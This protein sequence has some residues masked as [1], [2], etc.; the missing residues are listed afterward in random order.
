M[1]VYYKQK[2]NIDLGRIDP[3]QPLLVINQLKG[4]LYLPTCL[5]HVASLPKDFTRDTRAMRDIQAY[6]ISAP[7][8]RYKRISKLMLKLKENDEFKRWQISVPD[9]FTGIKGNILAPP[10]VLDPSG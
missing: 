9:T 2:Y 3:Q 5:C 10:K 1:I 6:K 7:D 4:N 8:D